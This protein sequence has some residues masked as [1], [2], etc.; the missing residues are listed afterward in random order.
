MIHRNR[1]IAVIMQ[2]IYN[3]YYRLFLQPNWTF[4][5]KFIIDVIGGNFDS[6]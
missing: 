2:N 3:K 6:L 4:D 1:K 5:T